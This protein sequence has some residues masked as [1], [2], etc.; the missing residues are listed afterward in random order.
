MNIKNTFNLNRKVWVYI[1]PLLI[2]DIAF[3]SQATARGRE[4]LSNLR[5]DI[6]ELQNQDRQAT[7]QLVVNQVLVSDSGDTLFING[8]NFDNGDF[9]VV[10][11]GGEELT[12]PLSDALQIT[13]DLPLS[14]ID[15]SYTL[16]VNTGLQ[17]SQF[18]SFE[19]TLG[20][21]G[22]QGLPG[23]VGPTGG[24]GDIGLQ[25]REGPS[26]SQGPQGVRGDAGPQGPRGLSQIPT[27][28]IPFPIIRVLGTGQTPNPRTN[29]TALCPNGRSVISAGYISGN[30]SVVATTSTR[31][32]ISSWRFDFLNLG[33]SETNIRVSL[34]CANF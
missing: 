20:A 1:L 16:T 3:H 4:S 33:N 10:E 8:V 2:V 5:N 22:P 6:S 31:S 19:L 32:G 11:L 17:R 18:D 9:P 26:G 25:G 30:G 7:S 15:G 13:T 29:S 28:S 23:P 21:V 14:F 12:V 27:Q 34:N 24:R